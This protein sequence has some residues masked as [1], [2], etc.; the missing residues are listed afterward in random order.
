MPAPDSSCLTRSGFDLDIAVLLVEASAAAYQNQD[1]VPEKGLEGTLAWAQRKG[2]RRG[3][4]A[5]DRGNIQG[6]WCASGDAALLSFRG[7]SNIKQWIRD[8]QFA[9]VS[10]PWGQV[11]KGFKEGL[12]LV[13]EDLRL[14]DTVAKEVKHVWITGHSL[15][16]AL[17]L[18]AAARLKMKGIRASLYTY[19]Q[20]RVG[21]GNFAD[22]FA[23]EL[24][25]RLHR[26]VNQS[27]IVARI[28][29]DSL[30]IRYN[31]TG[32][33]KRIVRPGVLE[34]ALESVR[35]SREIQLEMSVKLA[36]HSEGGFESSQASAPVF[37]PLAVNVG[38]ENRVL[39][40]AQAVAGAGLT[41]AALIDCELP[42]LTPD[43]FAALQLSLQTESEVQVRGLEGNI[44][45]TWL[46][47]FDDHRI[48]NY[49][50]LLSEI[51][52]KNAA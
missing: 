50:H 39:E 26:I 29:Q 8:A 38:L 46:P 19:G 17:A 16:G 2:F 48:K 23:I 15:G 20:P 33:V 45:K 4:G 34:T 49:I 31:H 25:G 27:D 28:P 40:T 43:E 30:L 1:P 47:W 24:P 13:E 32:I 37:Q 6:F 18:L 7:T 5:F 36:A 52:D 12:E 22:R 35:A 42:A 41:E 21:L 3:F 44:M 51:R 10:H 9:T 14:F 11:H